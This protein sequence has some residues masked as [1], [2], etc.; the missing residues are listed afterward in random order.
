MMPS[1]TTGKK[2][3]EEITRLLKLWIQ[4]STLNVEDNWSN[5]LKIVKH[6]QTTIRRKI[7]EELFECV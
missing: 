3:I 6:I 7:D 2:Y 4:D 1:C 5:T